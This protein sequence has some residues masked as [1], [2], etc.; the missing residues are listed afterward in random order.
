MSTPVPP[1]LA[2]PP[3][4][5]RPGLE[6]QCMGNK[7][8]VCA[9]SVF[10]HAQLQVSVRVRGY[11]AGVSQPRHLLSPELVLRGTH[12]FSAPRARTPATCGQSQPSPGKE[13]RSST[14]PT[15]SGTAA[16]P[17]STLH[18]HPILGWHRKGCEDPGDGS[19]TALVCSVEGA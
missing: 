17:A 18:R 15:T 14:L 9:P 3:P 6:G 5:S 2:R 4:P 7:T 8:S 16:A 11:R 10:V 1:R 19:G 13:G 12:S